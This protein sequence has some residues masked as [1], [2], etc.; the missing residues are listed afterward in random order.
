VS[1]PGQSSAAELRLRRAGSLT[2]H[3]LLDRLQDTDL[4]LGALV[5]LGRVLDLVREVE[6]LKEQPVPMHPDRDR[7]RLAT[8][9]ERADRDTVRSLERL[10]EHLIASLAILAGAEVG[11][12]LEIDGVVRRLR[13]VADSNERDDAWAECRASG[14]RTQ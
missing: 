4:R 8:P 12:V 1:R 11:R 2:R 10:D 13:A 5:D 6:P 3:L 14:G 7:G 9:G